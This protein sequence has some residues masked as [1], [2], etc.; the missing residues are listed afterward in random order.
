MMNETLLVSRAA[1][2]GD[3]DAFGRLVTLY[4][5]PVRRFFFNLTN[6]DEKHSKDLAQETFI[7]AWL[8]IGSFRAAAM[9]STW[10]YRIAYNVFCDDCRNRN[11]TSDL[12]ELAVAEAYNNVSAADLKMDLRQCLAQLKADERTVLTLFYIED[13]SIARIAAI[14]N[15]PT[16]T[17]KSHLH[18]GRENL[19]MYLK[20]YGYDQ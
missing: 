4:Q 14:M 12:E 20:K 19:A 8:H 18:R 15:C 13:L 7:K 2:L 6:G 9:F 5:S 3:K 17:V 1:L 16:G 11:W 10:L